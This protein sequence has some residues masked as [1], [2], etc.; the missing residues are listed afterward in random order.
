MRKCPHATVLSLLHRLHSAKQISLQVCSYALIQFNAAHRVLMREQRQV[1]S[2][3]ALV[4]PLVLI[5]GSPISSIFA[6][7]QDALKHRPFRVS[8]WLQLKLTGRQPTH[9]G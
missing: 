6:S 4:L 2:L 1:A 9:R 5:V 8:H 3:C 7:C